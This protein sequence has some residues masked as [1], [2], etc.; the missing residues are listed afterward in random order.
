MYLTYKRHH[1]K[2]RAYILYIPDMFLVC[3]TVSGHWVSIL[4]LNS[5][6]ISVEGGLGPMAIIR[7]SLGENSSKLFRVM[8]CFFVFFFPLVRHTFSFPLFLFSVF[9]LALP[10][11]RSHLCCLLHTR[12]LAN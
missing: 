7:L 2:K 6:L 11:L 4:H 10:I 3:C 9:P 12:E 5:Y 8:R 1:V